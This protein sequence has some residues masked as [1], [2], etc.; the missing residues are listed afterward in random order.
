MLKFSQVKYS[1][2]Y[3][4][5]LHDDSFFTVLGPGQ[6]VNIT[7]DRKRDI[8]H[9]VQVMLYLFQSPRHITSQI[10]VRGSTALRRTISSTMSTQLAK[11]QDLLLLLPSPIML[12]LPVPLRLH[13]QGLL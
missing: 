1:P 8:L 5:R 11:L 7:H 6:S 2:A 10:L 4:V 13:T 9:A 12:P 3:V